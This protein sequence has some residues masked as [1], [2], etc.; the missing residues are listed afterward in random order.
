MKQ[1]DIPIGQIAALIII[2]ALVTIFLLV[3]ANLDKFKEGIL[4]LL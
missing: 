3:I 2:V 1:G 4:G